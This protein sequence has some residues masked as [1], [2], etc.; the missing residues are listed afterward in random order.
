MVIERNFAENAEAQ[1]IEGCSPPTLA[2]MLHSVP[3]NNE[4]LEM[5]ERLTVNASRFPHETI[6][7]ET[8]LIDAE[9]GHVLLLAGFA[10]A[11]WDCLVSGA[12]PAILSSAIS[13]RFGTEAGAAT[14]KFLNELRAAEILVPTT[15]PGLAAN[16]PRSLPE[17][18]T[19][20]VLERY[21]DIAK[22]IAMDPIHDVDPSGWPRPS[23]DRKA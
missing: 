21:D 8:L 2:M 15:G 5:D 7:G 13:A 19:A 16:V 12:N 22:I 14:V 18:F 10:S 9:T 17:Q 11:L 23:N 4:W 3:R 20:P 6:D 1:A